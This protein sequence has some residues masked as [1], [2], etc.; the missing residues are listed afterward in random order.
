MVAP[1]AIRDA[2]VWEREAREVGFDLPMRVLSYHQ[3]AKAKVE[4]GGAVIFDEA[5]RLK[6]RKTQWVDNCTAAA[7]AAD[8]VHLASGTP[9][10]NGYLPELF[11]QMSLI[12][13]GYPAAYWKNKSGTGWV[14]RWFVLTSNRY[15]DWYV[16]GTL[17][18]CADAGCQEWLFKT[19]SCPC[20]TTRDCVH[21]EEF[22]AA[23]VGDWMLRRPET[24]LDLPDLAGFEEP[25][26]TPMT[27]TQR[28]VYRDLK[29][30]L[31][32]DIPEEGI[33]LEALTAS[34]KF[35]MLMMAATGLN[36]VDPAADAKNS[37]KQAYLRDILPEAERPVILGA[38]FR[39]TAA[40]LELMCKDLKLSYAMYG[41]G[42]PHK[43]RVVEEFQRGGTQVLIA[44][45]MVAREGITLTAADQLAFVERS[46]TPGDNEQ[47][48]RR[49]RRRGQTRTVTARQLVTP[50]S[51]DTGQWLTLQSKLGNIGA[52]VT[53]AEVVAML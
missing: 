36:S 9:T 42:T 35:Q 5:H 31:I 44:S 27:P 46:W 40:A 19:H 7:N 16:P 43:D 20:C 53:K 30:D 51:V 28:R 24:A 26:D 2:R 52:V 38:Y 1:A 22:W 34:S 32:A 41:A 21:R 13:P 8:R 37:G 3:M 29:K 11:A 25:L 47:F 23:N 4:P 39:S 6:S 45:I 50:D 48:V 17:K 15:S 12:H 10:P 33:T 49:A 18:G 14:E